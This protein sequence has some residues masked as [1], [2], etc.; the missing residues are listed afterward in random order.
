MEN[1]LLKRLK[2]FP[3]YL[4]RCWKRLSNSGKTL[5]KILLFLIVIAIIGTMC[6]CSPQKQLTNLL[7]RHPELR[8][9]TTLAIRA[10]HILHA[11][12]ADI[13]FTLADLSGSRQTDDGLLEQS[14]TRNNDLTV[15]TRSG[16]TATIS[17]TGK[18]TRTG[19]DIFNLSVKQPADT[20]YITDTIT[21]PAYITKTE[22][23]DRI[24]AQM[25]KPQKIFFGIGILATFLAILILALRVIARIKYGNL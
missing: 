7:I 13:D 25:N 3:A 9:D 18:Q 10:P 17:A 22:Y 12:S 4:K 6:S 15:S 24:V 1:N 2:G 14:R 20:I 23:K 16:A 19:E 5:I 21:I 11:D 8:Q